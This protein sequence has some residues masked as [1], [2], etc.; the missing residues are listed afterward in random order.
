[1]NTE[2][3]TKPSPELQ[4]HAHDL[5]THATQGVKDLHQDVTDAA[6]S[7]K[8]HATEHGKNL[9]KDVTHLAGDVKNQANRGVQAVREEAGARL[10]EARSRA[11]RSDRDRPG[12]RDRTS[13]RHLRLGSALRHDPG[14]V[15]PPLTRRKLSKK[16]KVM[17]ETK[18]NLKGN[19]NVVK[20]RLKQSYGQLTDD[21]LTYTEGQEDELVGRI[22]K[23]IGSTVADVRSLLNKHNRP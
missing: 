6:Q 8:D 22:Q 9:K 4:R 1:M 11:E 21:D 16:G 15:A 5:K 18:L 3:L 12:L 20:G 13:A 19:W 2:T 23:R 14:H 7:V 17:N 10:D